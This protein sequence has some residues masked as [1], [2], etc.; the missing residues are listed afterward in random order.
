MGEGPG[1]SPLDEKEHWGLLPVVVKGLEWREKPLPRNGDL[2]KC[3]RPES[4][5]AGVMAAVIRA[6]T[7]QPLSQ[8]RDSDPV[9]SSSL[10]FPAVASLPRHA[11]PIQRQDLHAPLSAFC[12]PHVSE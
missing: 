3:G 2:R 9:T 12:V 10:P 4:Q 6:W 11:L 8:H 5:H 1:L 7:N